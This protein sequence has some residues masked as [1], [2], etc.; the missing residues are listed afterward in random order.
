M[1]SL[2]KKIPVMF[3]C[4]TL[5]LMISLNGNARAGWKD[6]LNA[7]TTAVPHT[8]PT[9]QANP[10]LGNVSQALS[11]GQQIAGNAGVLQ[12]GSLTDVLMKKTGVNQ[13]QAAGGAGALLQLAKSKMQ[14]DA[15]S[16]LEQSV[17]GV[18]NLLGA[19]P[20]VQQP[21][22]L[23]GLAGRLSSVTGGAGGTAGSLVSLVSA[24]QQQGMSPQMIQQFIPVV[25]DYVKNSGGSALAGS[26]STA[27]TGL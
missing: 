19:V 3:V 16:K 4:S 2:M 27:L 18:Q 25:V 7:A 10:V 20:A 5:V 14:A 26:L 15:F 13:V 24:F 17:P 1:E 23:S 6:V 9:G 11:N 12:S 22:A 8:P 21:S